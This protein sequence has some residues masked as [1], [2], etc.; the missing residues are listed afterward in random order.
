MDPPTNSL[1]VT[2]NLSISFGGLKAVDSVDCIVRRGETLGLIGPNG[3]GK[4][5]FFNLIS[6]VYR[7][8]S[9]RILFADD[10]LAGLRPF[11]VAR[12]GIARTFQNNRLF[13]DLSVLDNVLIGMHYRQKGTLWET[14][15]R[16]DIARSELRK[17][18]SEGADLLR[19]FNEDLCRDRYKRVSDLPHA[20]RRRVEICRALASNPK[21]LL[22]DEPSAGMSPKETEELMIDIG[23]IKEMK[24]EI[25]IIVIEHDMKVIET[26][27]QWV[28]VFNYGRKIAEGSFEE[29][30]KSPAVLEAYLGEEVQDVEA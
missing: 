10:D 9:G 28:V 12:R 24:E 3:S 19:F 2:E 29:I 27:A 1:L 23:K 22:L 6:G 21:L 15:F 18:A 16:Y 5:T 7:P 17:S 30:S 20:D 13:V 14:I 11:Q 8:N 25:S 26:V 4:S